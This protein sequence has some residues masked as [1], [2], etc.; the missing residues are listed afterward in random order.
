MTTQMILR[1]DGDLKNKVDRLAKTEGKNTSALVREMLAEYVADHDPA[2][3]ID[4]LWA[5]I[6]SA[7]KKRRVTPDGIA[8]A[9]RAVRVER[10]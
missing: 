4:D 2:A 8:K 9:I 10:R 6:G 7:L 1:I 3:H 5:R